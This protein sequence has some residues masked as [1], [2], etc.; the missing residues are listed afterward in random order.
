MSN[1][2]FR[3][4]IMLLVLVPL[5]VS[6]A[7]I[8]TASV[9][10]IQGYGDNNIISIQHHLKEA[11][12]KELNN[13]TTLAV[14]SVKH[15]YDKPT[16]DNGSREEAKTILKNLVFGEDGYFFVYDYQ[17]INI[18]HPKKPQL[19]GKNL[20]ELSDVNGVKIIKE[21]VE[22]A[23]S[24]G[25]TVSYLWDKPSL[26]KKV[27]KL[28]YAKG[29]PEW[30]WMIGTG[31]YSDDINAAETVL[32]DE[33]DDNLLFSLILL[34]SIAVVVLLT[35]GLVTAKITL[36]EGRLADKKLKLLNRKYR[37]IQ[38]EV[39]G[40]L[41][42]DIKNT[43]EIPLENAIS[44]IHDGHVEEIAAELGKVVGNAA[45][46]VQDLRPDELDQL[47][48]FV[49]IKQLTLA[50]EKKYTSSIRL[51]LPAYSVRLNPRLETKIYRVV[52]EL[53]KNAAQHAKAK[54]IHLRL[55]KSGSQLHLHYQDDG[56]GF[57]S[58]VIDSEHHMGVG[59]NS[60]RDQIESENGNINIFST[61]NVGTLIRANIPII[62]THVS[63]SIVE[64][65]LEYGV[66]G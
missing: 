61:P 27:E 40:K 21:L 41:A 6:S 30:K 63:E 65:D 47:G 18:A 20:Y 17:G 12:K 9:V 36:H 4:K 33:L 2:S 46:L 58:G 8:T 44:S 7:A 60:I 57:I 26:G 3:N 48:L 43:I 22:A 32:K 62:E 14:S 29:L 55:R 51:G 23:K 54:T 66:S 10:L 11:R 19:E 38:E 37:D 24:G 25:N 5:F 50:Y 45:L 15:L 1:L 13:Y 42:K 28:G 49:A 31:L 16:F 53:L 64:G 56:M 35:T 39:R 59:L 34:S 52:E